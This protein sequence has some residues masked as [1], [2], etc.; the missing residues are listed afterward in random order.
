MCDAQ[1]VQTEDGFQASMQERN[2]PNASS[3]D[4]TTSSSSSDDS[5]PKKR[6]RKKKNKRQRRSEKAIK[7]L[8]KQVCDLRNYLFR[9]LP[10]PMPIE[11]DDYSNDTIMN[12]PAGDNAYE[13]QT[14]VPVMDQP[15]FNI[16][17]GTSVKAPVVPKTPAGYMES[18]KNFQRFEDQTWSD[19]RFTEVE[20][21]YVHSPGFVELEVNDEVKSYESSKTTAY[22]EKSFAALTYAMLKQKESLENGLREFLKWNQESELTGYTEVKEK[23]EAIF[24]KGDM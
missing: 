10:Q 5:A 8:S 15:E 3:S 2:E 7:Q 20:K 4:D 12:T 11:A 14:N 16:S 21:S 13:Q 6:S 24:L 9:P 23:L 17:L 1:D 19:I 18:L 22:V